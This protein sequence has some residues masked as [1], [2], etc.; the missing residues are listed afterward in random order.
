MLRKVRENR[1]TTYFLSLK[2]KGRYGVVVQAGV[3]NT[4][5]KLE[6]DVF[7]NRGCDNGKTI[8]TGI[9]DF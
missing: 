8:E 2:S 5:G 4:N 6:V 1:N 9:T 3:K 7:T